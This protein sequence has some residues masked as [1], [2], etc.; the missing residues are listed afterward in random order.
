MYLAHVWEQV[1]NLDIAVPMHL[2][3]QGRKS[4][5]SPKEDQSATFVLMLRK[6]NKQQFKD[7]EVPISSNL[8]STVRQKQEAELAEQEEMKRLVLDYNQRQEEETY[9]GE[10][11]FL[12]ILYLLQLIFGF[13]KS[14]D[15]SFSRFT[16][17][18]FLFWRSFFIFC[19]KSTFP[20]LFV[21]SCLDPVFPFSILNVWK[22]LLETISFSLI[23]CPNL[24]P[25]CFLS[26]L[27]SFFF[28]SFFLLSF[29]LAFSILFPFSVS[30]FSVF[31]CIVSHPFL[32]HRNDVSTA[33]RGRAW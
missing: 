17:F 4:A 32:I 28:P 22:I 30:Y 5:P 23:S 9:Y 25:G 18:L 8:A 33:P 24:N 7:F 21:P 11:T 12:V 6:G 13:L 27:L 10:E 20:I 2:K 29:F 1:P 19:L 31:C 15:F 16:S 3:G 26:F 14:F